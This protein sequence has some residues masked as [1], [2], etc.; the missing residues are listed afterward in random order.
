MVS[1][2]VRMQEIPAVIARRQPF[3]ILW[4]PYH[5]VEIDDCVKPTT[6][7]MV[8]FGAPKG[9]MVAP[10]NGMLLA[11]ER[12]MSCSYAWMIRS[13]VSVWL[14]VVLSATPMSLT[15]SKIIAYFT[16]DCAITSLSKRA[17]TFGPL[18]SRRIL[19]APA[20]WLATEMSLVG[21]KLCIRVNK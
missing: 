2:L 8:V 5:R 12:V 10:K 7:W 16:P 6:L 11:C 1:G 18:P 9:V 3:G 19:L 20:A 21:P 17:R 15:P 14:Y 4:I 13:P